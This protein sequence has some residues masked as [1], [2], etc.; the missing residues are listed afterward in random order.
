MYYKISI[1]IYQ[2]KRHYG[3][4]GIKP[5]KN[6]TTASSKFKQLIG[7]KNAISEASPHQYGGNNIL[8]TDVASFEIDPTNVE[9]LERALNIVD[10]YTGRFEA[11]Q[12][13]DVTSKKHE[14]TKY[15]RELIES[16]NHTYGEVLSEQITDKLLEELHTKSFKY[17][18]CQMTI[19][20]ISDVEFEGSRLT[21]EGEYKRVLRTKRIYRLGHS[22]L[23]SDEIEA[24][25]SENNFV[26][27][28]T[29]SLRRKSMIVRNGDKITLRI[30]FGDLMDSDYGDEYGY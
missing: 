30:D 4:R 23:K 10:V 9:Q 11:L 20:I 29:R 12:S 18:Q 24:V 5:S 21:P 17:V 27:P 28:V 3:S 14:Y 25:K 22:L 26:V 16:Y 19:T 6:Q 2:E 1:N 7:R 8:K 15:K 13:A